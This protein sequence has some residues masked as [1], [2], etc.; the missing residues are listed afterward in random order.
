[1][2]IKKINQDSNEYAVLFADQISIK[3]FIN[4]TFNRIFALK[5]AVESFKRSAELNRK[6]KARLRVW[7]TRLHVYVITRPLLYQPATVVNPYAK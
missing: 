2:R 1:M 4:E 3:I 5:Q 7:K 6:S